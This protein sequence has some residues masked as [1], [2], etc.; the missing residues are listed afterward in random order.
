MRCVSAT[1]WHCSRTKIAASPPDR[2]AEVKEFTAAIVC[3]AVLYEF[4]ALLYNG[5]Y[6]DGIT[7][8]LFALYLHW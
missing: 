4:D 8:A 5:R 1:D 7:R 3:L 2:E 6:A